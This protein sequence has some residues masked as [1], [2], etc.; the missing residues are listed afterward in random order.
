MIELVRQMIDE[1]GRLPTPARLLS[2]NADLYEIGLTSFAAV[3]VMLAL[4]EALGLQFP[5]R[6]LRRQSFGSIAS[7]VACL[8]QLERKAA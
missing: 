4:E 1:H 3:E 6:M 5:E 2:P 8:R 7:I